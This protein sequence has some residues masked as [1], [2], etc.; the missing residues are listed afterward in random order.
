MTVQDFLISALRLI[1]VGAAGETPG[2][3]ELADA[4]SA[5]NDLLSAWNADHR[6]IYTVVNRTH[7][8]TAGVES[9]TMGTG[10]AI[11]APRPI[12]IESAGITHLNGLRTPVEPIGSQD[13]AVI[14]EKTARSRQPL[15][16]YN[17][18]DYPLATLYLWPAPAGAVTLDLNA[19]EELTG[20]LALADTLALP[21]AYNRALR[22]NLAVDLAAE[23]GK[24]VAAEVGAIA[25]ESKADLFALNASNE[26]ATEEPPAAPAQGAPAQ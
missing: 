15:Q 12:K 5:F 21:P 2:T 25:K 6:T 8:L 3:G 26:S 4:L 13:Y 9:Y 18:N 14:P 17:D 24:S 20:P 7:T 19:W 1:N 11:N 23:W 10:G 22:Y 16:I